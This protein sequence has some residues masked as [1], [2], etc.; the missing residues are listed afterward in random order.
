MTRLRNALEIV[1]GI[2]LGL[3]VATI[4]AILGQPIVNWTL[5]HL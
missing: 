2:I 3:F 1:G 4:L 5:D